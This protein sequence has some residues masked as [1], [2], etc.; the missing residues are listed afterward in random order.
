MIVDKLTENK[1]IG[2]QFVNETEALDGVKSAEYY[3]AIII[4]KTF[5]K[6]MLSITELELKKPQI[7]YYVNEKKNAIAR[8]SPMPG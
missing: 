3:A 4:P 5:S 6:D 2:W 8:K 7:D 1:Q